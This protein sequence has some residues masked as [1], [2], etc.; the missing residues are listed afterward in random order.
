[1]INNGKP[2]GPDSIPGE[3][4]KTEVE[5]PTVI[6]YQ[7]RGEI[8]DKEE[9][10]AEWKEGYIVKLPKKGDLQECQNYRGIML[11]SVPGKVLSRVILE[12]LKTAVDEKLRDQQ[13][14]FR[15]DRSCTDQ[16]AT[17]RIILEQSLEWNSSLYINFLDN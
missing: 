6:L 14:G 12:R 4:L 10:P 9:L 5:T 17:M 1:M 13:A 11:L 16:I 3:A 2:A 7:L 8:W 15:K